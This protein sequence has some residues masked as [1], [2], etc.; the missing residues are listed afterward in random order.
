MLIF[1]CDNA[2]TTTVNDLLDF[3][4]NEVDFQDHD[5][6]RAAALKLNALSNDASVVAS[7]MSKSILDYF[8]KG[9][10]PTSGPQSMILGAR[11][12]FYV[13]ANIWLPLA[14][15]SP[16]YKHEQR[17]YSYGSAHNHNFNFMTVSHFGPGYETDLYTVTASRLVGEIGEQTDL[18]FVG[19]HSFPRSRVMVYEEHN[20]VHVQHPPEAVSI[21]INLMERRDTDIESDQYYFD[22]ES[23]RISAIPEFAGVYRRASIVRLAAEVADAETF[24]LLEGLYRET[25]CRRIKEALV[26]SL[27]TVGRREP[28]FAR[29]ILSAASRDSDPLVKAQAERAERSISSN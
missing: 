8:V 2:D 26:G 23:G 20:D 6:L 1:D 13:R 11:E 17:L 5:S 27:I 18:R 24:D 22:V 3:A 15:Q 10:L 29:S 9:E 4:E 19:R 12:R 16:F 25:S 21:S 14:G 28:E 7:F